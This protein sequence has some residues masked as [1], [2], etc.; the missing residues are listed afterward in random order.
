MSQSDIQ[1][2]RIQSTPSRGVTHQ[3]ADFMTR[4]SYTLRLLVHTLSDREARRQKRRP[5]AFEPAA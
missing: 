3:V 1:P 4:A 5:I 2:E